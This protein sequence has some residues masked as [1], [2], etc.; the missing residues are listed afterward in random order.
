MQPRVL[1]V[2]S[3][4]AIV[5][6]V[7]GG[8]SRQT[9]AALLPG[10]V[11]VI[12]V[13]TDGTTTDATGGG[14]SFAW[15]PLVNLSAGEVIHFSDTG[16]F[17][18]KATNNG[19]GDT[20]GLLTFTV[21]AGGIAAGVVQTASNDTAP[22]SLSLQ[23]LATAGTGYTTGTSGYSAGGHINLSA[24][25]D[26]LVVFQD[27]DVSDTAGF[28]AIFAVT[29]ASSKWDPDDGVLEDD[30]NQTGLYVGLADGVNAVAAGAGPNQ[31]DEFDNVRYVGP[32]TG[33]QA[34]LL[35]SI[36]N[37]NNWEGTDDDQLA[38]T[39]DW[40][41]NGVAQ[42]AIVPEPTTVCL[43]GAAI[44]CLGIFDRQRR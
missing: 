40:S 30:S 6:G 33:T 23:D 36:A 10:D 29:T 16:Y 7:L 31:Q 9:F 37:V 19:F 24:A 44:V 20:E 12:G 34:S 42:F 38:P 4:L 3:L 26:Q 2:L 14:D 28:S 5:A 1:N 22:N 43:L 35:A 15:V 8:G 11:A 18:S 25:G 32:T 39:R 13:Y 17:A 41:R 27:S 21:P